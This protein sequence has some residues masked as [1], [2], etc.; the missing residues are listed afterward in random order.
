MTQ[1]CTDIE[2]IEGVA[3]IANNKRYEL[4]RPHRH[5]HCIQ[6]AFKENNEET[7]IESS[8][9][10]TNTGRYVSREEALNIARNANQLLS[11]NVYLAK[12]HSEL[13]W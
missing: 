13:V 5:Q 8:G 1:L 2:T 4:P 6:L 10:I 7:I 12:L 3:V 9:F 11:R